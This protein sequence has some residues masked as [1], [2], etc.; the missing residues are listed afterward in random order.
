MTRASVVALTLVAFLP[1]CGGERSD[2]T[3][4]LAG[5]WGAYRDLGPE[6]R[7]VLTLEHDQ[8]DWMAEIGGVTVEATLDGGQIA[9][10]LPDERGEFRGRRTAD[11]TAVVGHW[12]QPRTMHSGRQVA[13]PVTLRPDGEG[14][15]QGDVV[16]FDDGFTYFL[17]ARPR[18]D[19]SVGA[20]LRNPERNFGVFMNIDRLER[21]G[22]TVR[23][24]GSWFRN[25]E[26][27]VLSEGTYD[28]ERDVLTF[29]LR[30]SAFD[31]ERIDDDPESLF[32]ARGRDPG[33]WQYQP[34]AP[35]DDGWRVGTLEE[36]GI[37][38]GPIRELIE[39]VISAPADSLSAPYVHGMLVA[40][41]GVLVL[42]EYFHGFD[43]ETPH[44][45]RSASKSLT[46]VL[47]GAAIED[48]APLDRSTPVLSAI[49]GG[50][51]P[52]DSD[53]RKRRMTVE[54]LLTMSS[55]LDCD[56]RDSSS[57]GNE[58][59]MQEQEDE[60]DWYRYTLALSMIREPGEMAVYC[61]INSNLLGAVL[62]GATGE[63]LAELFQRLIAEPLEIDR[64][65]LILDPLG[66]PY[67]GGGIQWLPRDFMKLG[68]LMLNG[69]EWNG[70]RVVSEEWV[71][72]SVSAQT[73]IRDRDYGYQWWIQEYPHGEG[74]VQAFFAGGNGGQVVIGVPELDLLV[75]FYAGNYSDPVLYVIQEEFVPRYVLPA[76]D[77]VPE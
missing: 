45:T 32:Y 28:P 60:P 17:V 15:W 2:P 7:G 24:I 40:R 53:A 18:P 43:R 70:R 20:F 62:S 48:G 64:Y 13:S 22:D 4:E 41:N 46:A 25:A 51:I 12:I 8:S 34:P 67:M 23:L 42:E 71:S 35:T 30:G 55:G 39:D 66:R 6:V 63:S 52:P 14:R 36:A 74:T 21:A 9:F 68:Q 58:D 49:H 29:T 57:P 77:R 33:P 5:I 56:D 76:V 1:S 54:H 16:P 26:V 73:R 65:H 72:R 47:V 27:E 3:L 31:F 59:V 75:T 61:S 11:G 38:A 50:E 19:G 10:V 44:D 69:G 37:A